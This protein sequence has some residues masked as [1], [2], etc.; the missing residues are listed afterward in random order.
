MKKSKI[1]VGLGTAGW[2]ALLLKKPVMSFDNIWYSACKS[3][4]KVNS[5]NE[6]KKVINKIEDNYV[7]DTEDVKKYAET[8]FSLSFKSTIY[9]E[10]EEFI[11]PD[12][13]QLKNDYIKLADEFVKSYNMHYLNEK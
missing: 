10:R 6:I 13:L 7:V 2:E 9:S 1:I 4:F 5:I 12:K 11:V 3:V 8:I